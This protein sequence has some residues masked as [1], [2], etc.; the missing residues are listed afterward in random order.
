MHLFSRVQNSN[1]HCKWN[2]S[3]KAAR[4][5]YM[6]FLVCR[7]LFPGN[8]TISV[9]SLHKPDKNFEMPHTEPFLQQNVVYNYPLKK[10]PWIKTGFVPVSY[11]FRDKKKLINF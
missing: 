4:P 6:D 5:I 7:E 2:T 3:I 9:I 1:V 10:L 11:V 8:Y